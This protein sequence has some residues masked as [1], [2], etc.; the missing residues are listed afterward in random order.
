[1]HQ[2]SNQY[3]Q[4]KWGQ[5]KQKP[6]KIL[7]DKGMN[8]INGIFKRKG[9]NTLYERIVMKKKGRKEGNISVW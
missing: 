1:L 5:K 3:E 2:R 8:G 4:R 7:C 9:G 6:V